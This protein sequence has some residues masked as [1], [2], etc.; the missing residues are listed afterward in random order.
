MKVEIKKLEKHEDERGW[1]VEMLRGDQIDQEIKN[2]YFSISKPGAIRGNHYHKRKTE[3]F[4]TV[5]GKA[6]LILGDN[7]SREKR[8]LI[9]SGDDPTTIK[10]PPNVTHLIENIGGDEMH[11]IVIVNEVFNPDDPD[12]LSR[13]VDVNKKDWGD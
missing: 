6:R 9:L 5:K 3:W 11:L 2:I 1:L 8:E 10:I 12:T 4:C 7:K 13:K